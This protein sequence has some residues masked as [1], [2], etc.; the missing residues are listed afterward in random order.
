MQIGLNRIG[1]GEFLDDGLALNDTSFHSA[2]VGFTFNGKKWNYAQNFGMITATNNFD[3]SHSWYYYDGSKYKTTYGIYPEKFISFHQFEYHVNKNYWY[4]YYETSVFGQKFDYSY[5]IPCPYM[6]TQSLSGYNDNISMGITT[7]WRI[8]K[9]LLWVVDVYVDDTSFNDLVKL[10]L[11]SKQ[12]IAGKTGIIASPKNSFIDRIEFNYTAITPYT[13]AHWDSSDEYYYYTDSTVNYQNYTNSGV[14]IGSTLPPNTMALTFKME[15]K[16][17]SKLTLSF[18]SLFAV[19]GNVTESVSDESAVNYLLSTTPVSSDGSIYTNPCANNTV[20]DT[21]TT[22]NF[23]TQDHLMYVGQAGLT[24]KV[25]IP[26]KYGK[27]T[28]HADYLFQ[29]VI[30]KGVDNDIYTAYTVSVSDGQEITG[31]TQ[32]AYVC[33]L[34]DGTKYTKVYDSD[35]EKTT[36]Y[37]GNAITYTAPVVTVSST[38][39]DDDG[40]YITTY[41]A[42]SYTLSGTGYDSAAS[43]LD[44]DS[45]KEAWESSFK[46]VFSNFITVGLTYTF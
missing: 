30:N 24:A 19:H 29:A 44:L 33:T 2:N 28:L 22:L 46:N 25:K 10:N 41:T 20:L 5:L 40:N 45:F 12:R 23:L 26:V 21:Y 36:Y 9:G 3:G 39:I 18:N 15:A 43:V 38:E 14:N 11:N 8:T 31:T 16:P 42:E 7:N 37:S 4:T 35:T 1:Y 6:I 17:V 13:Y 34:S 32:T 27:L